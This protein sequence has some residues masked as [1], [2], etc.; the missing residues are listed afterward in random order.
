[1]SGECW[2][3][4]ARPFVAVGRFWRGLCCLVLHFLI[5]VFQRFANQCLVE[6]HVLVLIDRVS[7]AGLQGVETMSL[8]SSDR[9]WADVV[10]LR[11]SSDTTSN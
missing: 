6:R 1:L 5:H 7:I 9:V 8:I 11:V 2:L 4:L 10:S 3:V